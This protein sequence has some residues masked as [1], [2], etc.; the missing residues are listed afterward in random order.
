MHYANYLKM[1]LN[2]IRYDSSLLRG[3]A[4]LLNKKISVIIVGNQENEYTTYVENND[5]YFEFYTDGYDGIKSTEI[6]QF[7]NFL[8]YEVFEIH[9]SNFNASK[10]NII[11]RIY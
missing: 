11:N 8:G 5:V 2:G 6:I 10:E 1:V 4:K 7:L 9:K 3:G